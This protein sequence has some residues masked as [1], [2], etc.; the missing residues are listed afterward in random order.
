MPLLGLLADLNPGPR[1][2]NLVALPPEQFYDVLPQTDCAVN[3][4]G[5]QGARFCGYSLL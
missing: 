2:P 5:Q 1:S 4:D 3:W